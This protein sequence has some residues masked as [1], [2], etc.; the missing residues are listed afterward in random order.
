[1][2]PLCP[3]CVV[4]RGQALAGFQVTFHCPLFPLSPLCLLLFSLF[5]LP[6]P[7]L[8]LSPSFS[9]PSPPLLPLCPHSPPPFPIPFILA[10]LFPLP[11]SSLFFLPPYMYTAFSPLFKIFF[12]PPLSSLYNTF[13]YP[14]HP[15][16]HSHTGT[17]YTDRQPAGR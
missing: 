5:L 11:S 15:H 3:G 6:L 4:G 7:L 14:P 8:S 13:L 17:W 2:G 1:M 12:P 9:F 10:L 16:T